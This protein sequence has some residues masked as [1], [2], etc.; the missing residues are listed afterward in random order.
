[1]TKKDATDTAPQLRPPI[2][3]LAE[4]IALRVTLDNESD[5]LCERAYGFADNTEERC[6]LKSQVGA[7]N[8]RIDAIEAFASTLTPATMA[9][10]VALVALGMDQ[11]GYASD[12]DDEPRR[13]E[14]LKRTM[15]ALHS[16]L[17]F[18]ATETGTTTGELSSF[19]RFGGYAGPMAAPTVRPDLAVRI[20]GAS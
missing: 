2:A 17:A 15:A 5:R 12:E 8:E 13:D 6:A 11:A 14:R 16:A 10:A 19:C 7:L 18:L 4:L 20:G 9:D 1:M 3:S